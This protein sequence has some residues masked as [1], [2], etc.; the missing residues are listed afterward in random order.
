MLRVRGGRLAP[1]VGA[2]VPD[3]MISTRMPSMRRLPSVVEITSDPRG[4]LWCDLPPRP[5]RYGGYRR[6]LMAE[7]LGWPRQGNPPLSAVGC[8]LSV[9]SPRH[10]AQ[11]LAEEDGG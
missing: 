1:P 5:L 7:G 3:D 6:L 4:L 2:R 10:H 9:D 8:P 11:A